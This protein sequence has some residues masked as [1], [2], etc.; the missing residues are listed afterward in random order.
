MLYQ[1]SREEF[2][3]FAKKSSRVVISREIYGDLLTPIRVFQSLASSDVDAVLLDSSDHATA[4]DACIYIGVDPCADFNV[5]QSGVTITNEQGIRQVSGDPFELLRSFYNEHKAISSDSLSKFAGGMIGFLGYD[6]IRFVENI[7]DKHL[8]NGFPIM[9]FKF[10][11]T[12]VVFDKRT[13]KALITQVVQVSTDLEGDFV[14]AMMSI[15]AII[16][17]MM[18]ASVSVKVNQAA[19]SG[20]PF[21]EVTVDISDEKYIE[22]VKQAQSYI[23]QGDIF[24][25]VLSRRFQ[26]PYDADPFDIYRALRV[27]NPSPYQFYIANKDYVVVGSSP[28]KLVSVQDGIIEVCPIAGTRPRGETHEQDQALE[29]N[30]MSDEKELAEHM[31]LVDLGRNDVGRVSEAGSVNVVSLKEVKRFSSVMHI[32]STVQGKIKAGYDAINV[33]QSTFPAGTLTG[34]PKIRAMEIID[35]LESS[36]RN[37]YGGGIVAIDNQGQMDAS[38]VIRTIVLKDG[39]ATARAGAGVVL[40]SDPQLEADETRH[41]V[42]GVFKALS[43]A[44]GGVL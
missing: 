2:E 25:V 44:Q 39:V 19:Q 38:I 6:A 26:K 14:K 30:L 36:K 37:L 41:K 8:C 13:G 15:D 9:N 29:Q 10:Y 3:S 4:Q 22:I 20:D 34:A 5:D 21:D 1:T 17:K 40:D 16:E 28:E 42:T 7:P 43:L 23:K 12:N 31:M 18:C 33:L 11:S 24:Q 27:L 35:A 32:C